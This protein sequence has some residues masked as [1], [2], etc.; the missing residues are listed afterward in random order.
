MLLQLAQTRFQLSAPLSVTS[1]AAAA[2]VAPTAPKKTALYEFHVSRGG[3]MVEFAG[4]SMPVQYSDLGIPASHLHT[5]QNVSLFDVSHML[6]TIIRGKDRVEFIES[7]VVGD[8]AGLP[9]NHAALTLFTNE[10]GGIIDDLIVT[11]TNLGYL[12]VVSNAGCADKDLAHMLAQLA[13]FKGKGKDVTLD[14]SNNSLL[15]VQG[16]RMPAVLQT[17][18]DVDLS[19]LFFMTSTIATVYGV[20][21]CRLTRCGYTG[22][23]GVEISVPSDR[24]VFVAERLLQHQAVSVKLAGLGAR[25]SLRLEAG[26][27]LYGNDI[28]DKTTPVEASLVW[29][30]GKR[31][32]KDANFPGASIIL[33]QLADKPSKKRVGFIS[34]GP[35]ARGGTPIMDESGSKQIGYVTSGCPSPSLKKNVAIGYVSTDQ[36]AVGKNVQFEVRKKLTGAQVAKMP[37][38]PNGYYTPKE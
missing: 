1:S 21:N 38:V 6:Q 30:I 25:D 29:T 28:D 7:L 9:D 31:R 13:V 2:G 11:K 5:R 27:C 22:E 23:D 34:V 8:I 37:F 3:K 19:K 14:V 12:Y 20:P 32:R 15:A 10:H 16:P 33:K 4:W 17:A 36:S 24:A 26:L 35:P 18:T